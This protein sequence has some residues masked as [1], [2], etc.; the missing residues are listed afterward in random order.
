MI[1]KSCRLFGQDHV[2]KSI[3]ESTMR[4]GLIASC[5]STPA[6]QRR[7]DRRQLPLA[8]PR[9]YASPPQSNNPT[10]G[11][12]SVHATVHAPPLLFNRKVLMA[13]HSP[14]QGLRPYG[15]R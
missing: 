5:S 12:A 11:A 15:R 4:L 13:A 7:H 2:P 6:F 3:D 10:L 14:T 1:P 9:L 8:V